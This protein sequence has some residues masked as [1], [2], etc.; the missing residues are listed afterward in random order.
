MEKILEWIRKHI[1]RPAVRVCLKL[2]ILKVNDLMACISIEDQK[3]GYRDQML[4]YREQ[5][6]D[7]IQRFNLI[8]D[9]IRDALEGYPELMSKTLKAVLTDEM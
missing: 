1:S 5:F 8:E 7:L 3:K 6:D 9:N 4:F 2:G